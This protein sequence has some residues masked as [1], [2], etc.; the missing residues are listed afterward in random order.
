ML[1]N[2]ELDIGSKVSTFIIEKRELSEW[3]SLTGAMRAASL[4]RAIATP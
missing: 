3:R 4:D 1:G 2:T